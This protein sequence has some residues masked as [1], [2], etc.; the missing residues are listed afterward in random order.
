MKKIMERYHI[1]NKQTTEKNYN[2]LCGDQK[3]EW[4][5]KFKFCVFLFYFFFIFL[6]SPQ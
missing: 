6:P 5:N 4:G 3:I 1:D 2:R